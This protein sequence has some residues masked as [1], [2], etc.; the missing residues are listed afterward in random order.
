MQQR[1]VFGA[2]VLGDRPIETGS[3]M[4]LGLLLREN[5]HQRQ[6][7]ETIFV[8]ADGM[9][10][11]RILYHVGHDKRRGTFVLLQVFDRLT[12]ILLD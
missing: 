6:D 4:L 2:L 10:A 3:L 8:H 12:L 5:A 7:L 9:A 11:Q 1:K